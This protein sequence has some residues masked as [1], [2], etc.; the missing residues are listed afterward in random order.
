MFV[1]HLSF[2]SIFQM[3]NM[4]CGG[5]LRPWHGMGVLLICMIGLM[6]VNRAGAFL[7]GRE[8]PCRFLDSVNITDGIRNDDG[9]ITFNDITFPKDQYARINFILENGTKHVT[10]DPY[11]RGCLCAIKPCIRLCCPFGTFVDSSIKQGKKC[12]SHEAAKQFESDVIDANN[13]VDKV[14]LDNQFAFVD[15]RPCSRYYL[16]DSYNIT[17]VI[18]KKA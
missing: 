5:H 10:V 14:I 18:S 11:V 15:D 16:A 4:N 9:S 8:L 1:F 13:N 17:H 12:R 7:L 6:S 3:V 2:C